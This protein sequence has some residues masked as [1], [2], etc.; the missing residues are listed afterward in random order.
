M[1]A[2]VVLFAKWDILSL[3]EIPNIADS[4]LQGGCGE[5]CSAAH[6]Y[7]LNDVT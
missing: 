3:S 5:M 1:L 6:D 2:F 4:E 7:G